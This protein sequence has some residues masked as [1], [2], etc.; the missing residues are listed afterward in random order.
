MPK[1]TEDWTTTSWNPVTG[2]D[3]V[4]ASCDHRYGL[5][6]AARLKAM[7][8]S[9]T[10][11]TATRVRAGRASGDLAS[12]PRR[13]AP[14]VAKGTA[15]LR[16]QHERPV[17]S[18]R[19]ARVIQAVVATI[20]ATPQHTYQVLTKRAKRLATLSAVI[21]WPDNAGSA[22]RSSP[23]VT[24]TASNSCETSRRQYGSCRPSRCS[25]RSPA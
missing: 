10:S 11:V 8:R 9:A 12:R 17:P 20:R 16:R 15:R 5:D 7:A 3:R 4:S 21:D 1:L 22:R 18:A 14:K 13:R 25:A 24:C 2:C 19:A 23:P 6:F